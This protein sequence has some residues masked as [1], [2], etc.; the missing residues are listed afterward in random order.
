MKKQ[1]FIL[2]SAFILT[3]TATLGA[4]SVFADRGESRG[5]CNPEFKQEMMKHHRD[6]GREEFADKRLKRKEMFEREYSADQ[7]RTLTQARLIRQ[8]NNNLQVGKISS[9]QSGFIISIVTQDGSLVE[10]K[11][12]AKNGM[13]LEMY[14]HIKA[15]IEAGKEEEK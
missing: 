1:S 10:E 12:V 4:T 6:F 3:L 5:D 13:P 7:I 2:T 8:G 9:T 15:R 14:E 11:K